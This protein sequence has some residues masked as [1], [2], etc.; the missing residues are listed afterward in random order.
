MF[1]TGSSSADITLVPVGGDWTREVDRI[2][3]EELAAGRVVRDSQR[4]L[5]TLITELAKQKVQAVVLGCTELVLAVDVRANVLPV[6]D[7]T[8][9]HARAA[10]EWMLGDGGAGASSGLRANLDRAGRI[11]SARPMIKS[12]VRRRTERALARGLEFQRLKAQQVRG[13][14]A[15]LIASMAAHSAAVHDELSAV[16]PIAADAKVLEVGSGAHGLI[17]YFEGSGEHVGVDPL[18]DHYRQLFPIWHSRART[19]AAFGEDLPFASA[20]FDVVLC[21]NVVDHAESP[22]RIVGEL[23]RVLR[24][25]GSLYFTV[26]VHHPAYHAAATL[27]AAWRALGIPFE[28]TPFADHTVH[29]TLKSA[30]QLFRGL[31][32]DIVDESDEIAATKRS[33]R[34]MQPRHLGDRLKRLFFKNSR[35]K[36]IAVRKSDPGQAGA[37]S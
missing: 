12:G 17:F 33:A 37:V 15:Q 21:D 8:A 31:P 14:E 34:A 35:W 28:I 29:L 22:R 7:T 4:K 1:A 13:H 6:Y 9:I 20:S 36:I 23:V 30:R 11:W 24:P 10:V 2:I 18:A 32:L 19:L 27:H 26:N 16:R 5:K 3:F 25:G